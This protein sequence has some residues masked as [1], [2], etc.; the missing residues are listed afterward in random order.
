[1]RFS[2][3]WLSIFFYFM[4]VINGKIMTWQIFI[5]QN[6]IRYEFF[7]TTYLKCSNNFAVDFIVLISFRMVWCNIQSKSTCRELS[8]PSTIIKCKQLFY[9]VFMQSYLF[10]VV[11][12]LNDCSNILKIFKK[13]NVRRLCFTLYI[14]PIVIVL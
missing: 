9:T 14:I 10:S 7:V 11:K 12:T 1:M 6:Y 13:F 4:P 3:V 2:L 5:S 8:H